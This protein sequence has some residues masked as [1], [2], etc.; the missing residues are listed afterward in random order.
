[1]I[2]DGAELPSIRIKARIHDA[3]IKGTIVIGHELEVVSECGE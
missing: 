3:P 2:G 1:M